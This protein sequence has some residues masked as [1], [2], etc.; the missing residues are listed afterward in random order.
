M[1]QGINITTDNFFIC[2]KLAQE[3]LKENM[4]IVGTVRRNRTFL[5]QF[6]KIKL[7]KKRY[8]YTENTTLLNYQHKKN[9]NVVMLSTFHTRHRGCTKRNETPDIVEFYNKTKG[10]SIV[11]T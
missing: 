10:E 1:Y 2:Y 5:P 4:T 6:E 3:L 11:L 7:H 9:K 8:F